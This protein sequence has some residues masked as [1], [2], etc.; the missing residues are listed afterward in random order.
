MKIKLKEL[1]PLIGLIAVNILGAA[2][3]G[4]RLFGQ[5]GVQVYSAQPDGNAGLWANRETTIYAMYY[6]TTCGNGSVIGGNP[7]VKL[8]WQYTNNPAGA[9]ATISLSN[10]GAPSVS[11][12]IVPVSWQTTTYANY[13]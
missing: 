13:P 11:G 8:C 2:V 1:G 7:T 4:S 10:W 6:L 9:S 12:E 5:T 3:I